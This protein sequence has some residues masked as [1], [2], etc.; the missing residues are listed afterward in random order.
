MAVFVGDFHTVE[1]IIEAFDISSDALR[2]ATILFASYLQ[3]YYDGSAL[4]LFE[5]GGKLY[6]VNGSH[7]SCYGLE[8]QWEPEET[9]MAAIRMRWHSR[10]V[11]KQLN[12]VLDQYEAT[13]LEQEKR[14]DA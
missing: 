14:A 1:D 8:D 4:V 11:R 3:G 6:E 10:E 12:E 13:V 2:E 5:R 7:C 9:S